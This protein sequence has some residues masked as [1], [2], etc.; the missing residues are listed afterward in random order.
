[1]KTIE[2]SAIEYLN[3]DLDIVDGEYTSV[4]ILNAF[5]AG[6][7]FAQRWIP[8]EEELPKEKG[9]CLVKQRGYIQI[10][11]WIVDSNNKGYWWDYLGITHWRPIELK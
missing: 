9:V 1:M 7:E 5:E 8:I 3:K 2:Q 4:A 11:R 6:A 10:G